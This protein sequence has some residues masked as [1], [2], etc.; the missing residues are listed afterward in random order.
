VQQGTFS[1]ALS[2]GACIGGIG[3]IMGSSANL[4]SM[5]ISQRYMPDSAPDSH[6]IVGGDFMK[7]GFPLLLVLISVASLY[8]WIAF[9][10]IG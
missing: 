6:K 2:V 3:S 8:Q 1:Y 9:S 10:V 4:V 5:G 7:H